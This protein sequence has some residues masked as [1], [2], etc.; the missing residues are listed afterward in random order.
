M[1]VVKKYGRRRILEETGISR[2]VA[3]WR[4]LEKV[5]PVKPEYVKPLLELLTDEE[6]ESLVVVRE[7]LKVLGVLRGEGILNYSLAFE[8]LATARGDEYLKTLY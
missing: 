7:E 1:H 2:R 8:I 3:L 6:L 5:S 4:L